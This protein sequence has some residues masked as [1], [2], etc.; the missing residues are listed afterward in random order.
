[1]DLDRFAADAPDDDAPG[2]AR[3]CVVATQQ[4]TFERCRAGFYP[5]PR[6]YDRTHADFDYMAFYRTA[7]VSAVTH[8]GR[9][10]DRTEQTRGEPGPMDEADW[11]ALIDPFSEERV[12][13]IFELDDLVPL[14]RRVDNDLNGVRGA[15]YCTVA[16]LR[17]AETL[18]VLRESTETGG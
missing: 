8:Y 18:S 16:D 12:V 17:T 15:W 14:E 9:V 3:V 1:M 11:A 13:V 4:E 6:S 7:P 5:A 10:V 2:D